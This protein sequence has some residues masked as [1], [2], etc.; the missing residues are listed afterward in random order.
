[1]TGDDRFVGDYLRSELLDRVSRAEVAFL[2][3]TSIL[4]RMCGEL[5][6][7]VVGQ[8]GSGRTLEQLEGRN[9]LVVPLDRRREWY[10]YHTLFRELLLAELVGAN[11]RSFLGCML[12]RRSGTRRTLCRRAPSITPWPRATRVKWLGSC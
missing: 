8:T 7:V 2:T 4:G 1:V 12:E 9:L 6:N 10:R 5:C 11:R 3:R